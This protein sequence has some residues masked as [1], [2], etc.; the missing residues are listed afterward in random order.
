MMLVFT[1]GAFANAAAMVAPVV[2]WEDRLGARLGV[3]SRWLPLTLGCVVALIVA[4]AATA[5][6]CGRASRW[7]GRSRHPA[8]ELAARLVPAWVPIGFAMWLAH[9]GFHLATGIG[10]LG[11]AVARALGELGLA[12][13]GAGALPESGMAM[14]G[15]A[16]AGW[17]EGA[18]IAVLG[19]GL[20]V[21]VAVAWRLCLGLAP[22][23][24]PAAALA[25][26]WVVVSALLYAV[27]VWIVLQPM[28]MRGMV[29]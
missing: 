11:P 17:L 22:G 24:R 26:P 21:S 12:G 23:P 6:A 19:G 1:F 7:L 25:A 29:M 4:P 16:L 15:G 18:E 27:G 13:A 20:V 14:A 3:E 2:A 5:L 10:T 28:Q 8:H 9:F